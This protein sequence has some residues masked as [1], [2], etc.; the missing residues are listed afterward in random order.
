MP[1]F[2][3]DMHL[4]VHTP[5][6][7]TSVEAPPDVKAGKFLDDLREPLHLRSKDAEGRRIQ[8]HIHDR[9]GKRLDPKR[10]LGDNG[11]GEGHDLF[12]REESEKPKEIG[13]PEE[14]EPRTLVEHRG[15]PKALVRCDNGHY[16][17][18][19]KYKACP[20]CEV[21]GSRK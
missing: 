1:S 18:P 5:D 20:Y 14:R 15:D 19:E 17:A 11:V 12:L 16:Y 6:G 4:H 7:K 21:R 2:V 9:E 3:R 13:A 10:T 8:W